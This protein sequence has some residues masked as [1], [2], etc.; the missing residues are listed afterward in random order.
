MTDQSPERGAK[1][2]PA[3][4]FVRLLVVGLLVLWAFVLG[5]LVGQGSIMS[6]K[7]VASLKESLTSLPVV[8]GW[9]KEDAPPPAQEADQPQLSFYRELERTQGKNPKP[10]TPTKPAKPA[11]QTKLPGQAAQPTPKPDPV[12]TS[13]KPPDKG[14]FVVQVASF[15]KKNQADDMAQRLIKAG[16][17]AY[18][19][20]VKLPEVGVRYRVRIGPFP[21]H[22]TAKAAAGRLRLQKQLAAYVTR[23][24]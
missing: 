19:R 17:S 15:K 1:A 13:A 8:G 7:Q 12:A 20:Q 6:P 11:K 9:F 23:E 14:A 24:D 16:Q 2:S 22:E 18:V 21:D 3:R 5:I 4:R 10:D